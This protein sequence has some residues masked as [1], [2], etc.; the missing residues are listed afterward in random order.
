MIFIFLLSLAVAGLRGK[1]MAQAI[2]LANMIRQLGGAVGI[3][4][5]NVFLTY[6]NAEVRGNMLSYITDYASAS[7][8]RIAGLTQTFI[9]K[10]YSTENAQALAYKMMEGTLFKQGALVSYDQGFFMVGI[11]ILFCIPVVLLIRYKKG[12]RAKPIADH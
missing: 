11:A 12:E 5:L 9:S 7:A 6:K 2:G 4:L 8:D 1:D 10:G 3:A